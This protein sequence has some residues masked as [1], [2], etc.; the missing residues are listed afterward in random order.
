MNHSAKS[1]QTTV[2]EAEPLAGANNRNKST[3]MEKVNLDFHF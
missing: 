2:A 1:G 3:V